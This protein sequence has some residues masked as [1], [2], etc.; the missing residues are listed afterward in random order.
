ML[1]DVN[2]CYNS[3]NSLPSIAE[4][5]FIIIMNPGF[6]ILGVNEILSKFIAIERKSII[7]CVTYKFINI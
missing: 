4:G 3:C 6:N 5:C 1:G 7:F 2:R